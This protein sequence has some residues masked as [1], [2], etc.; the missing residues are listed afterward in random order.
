MSN[1]Q[2]T[3][4]LVERW[5]RF[6]NEDVTRMVREI[7]APDCQVYPL[8]LGMIEGQAKLQ[9]VEDAVLVQAP[10]RRLDVIRT[11]IAGDTAC[12][13][14]ELRDPDRGAKWSVPF[15]AIL[16]IR[17][18]RVTIDRTYADWSRWPGL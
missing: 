6:Y 8:G 5:A 1:A 14:A 18:D 9:Q 13:E 16:T 2:A 4:A 12:V 15:I 10:H 17:D 3:Q 11:H 7:D